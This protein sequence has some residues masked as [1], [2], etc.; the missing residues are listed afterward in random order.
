MKGFGTVVTG[1]LL[2]GE[3]RVGESLALEPGGRSVRVRGMQTHGRP[4][5][6]A[7]A[8]S[9]VALNLAGIEV[10][11]ASRGQT[12]VAQ[13]TLT[14]VTTIDVE[15]TL[16]LRFRQPQASLAGPLSRFYVR[17]SGN[18]FV[19][20]LRLSR[21]WHPSIHAAHGSTSPSCLYPV[22]ASCCGNV[23][24]RPPSAVAACSMR[25]RCP[26]CAKGSALRGWKL[27]SMPPSKNS[28]ACES[29]GAAQPASPCAS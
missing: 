18:G 26:T 11:E 20:W 10:S 19:V 23:R 22:T 27:S 8:G 4:E 17:D 5:E 9:R 21:A 29:R 6:H 2:S 28:F 1:T 15:A 25:N 24:R 12:L 14:A 13:E 16:L 3:F 7:R